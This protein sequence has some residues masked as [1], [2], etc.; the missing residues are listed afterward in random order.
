M[1]KINSFINNLVI[2]Q[3]HPVIER[4]I[5]IPLTN[6][7]IFV[8]HDRFIWSTFGKHL[9]KNVTILSLLALF[10]T[11]NVASYRAGKH[12]SFSVISY[13]QYKLDGSL[14]RI[15]ALNDDVYEKKS[16]IDDL[17][18]F[19]TTR[20]YMKYKVYTESQ[21]LIPE[22][23]PT[24]H[25]QLMLDEADKYQVPYRILF[26]VA[27][28][29]NKFKNAPISSA[30]ATGYMQLMPGT[31]S[32]YYKKMKLKGG[33]T[34]ENNIKIGIYLLSS[35]H[36]KWSKKYKGKKAW[37]MSPSEYN[38]GI[39]HVLN[40]KGNIPNIKETKDYV[41]FVTKGL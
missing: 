26:R 18:S 16:T 14:V 5:T 33:H 25:L 36:I 11:F 3:R 40:A 31:F 12:Q 39:V 38:A 8:V 15:K 23:F 35:L 6:L 13:L 1:K 10:I 20:E 37:E 21:I 28:K 9:L 34:P 2:K 24:E 41:S 32:S 30:G 27:W 29:E 22:Y 4:Y 19:F 7:L 17:S